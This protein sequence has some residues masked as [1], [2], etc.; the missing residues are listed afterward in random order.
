M[1]LNE[2]QKQ[3]ETIVDREETIA[4][5]QAAL[6]DQKK[7]IADQQKLLLSLIARVG[8]VGRVE[9]RERMIAA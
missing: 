4:E 7:S 3:H 1:L 5:R 9:K 8:G 6:S 2:F